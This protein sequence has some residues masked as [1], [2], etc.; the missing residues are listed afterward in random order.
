MTGKTNEKTFRPWRDVQCAEG[1]TRAK[2]Y[3]VSRVRPCGVCGTCVVN[4]SICVLMCVN[5]SMCV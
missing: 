3:V 4:V 1:E 2:Y 5:E